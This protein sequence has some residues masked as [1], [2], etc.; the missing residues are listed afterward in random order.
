MKTALHWAQIEERSFVWGMRF[1]LRVYLI[2]GRSILQVF[3][4]PV[5]SY[6]WLLNRPARLASQAYLDR[7]A[8]FAPQ[9]KLH[10]SRYWSYCHFIS[11][12][13][14]IIDKL[15][16]WSG[17]LAPE[18]VIYRGRDL[19]L[20]EL[21]KGRGLLLLGA[22]LGNLEVCRAIAEFDKSIRINVLVHTKHAQKFN[23]LLNST[24][25]N[26]RLNL[27]QVTEITAA[28][29]QMLYDKIES[30]E[31]IIMAADRIPVN[32]WQ[33]TSKVNFLG[34]DAH[35]PQGPFILAGLLKC[36]VY[37]LICLKQGNKFVTY[38]EPFSAPI[39]FQKHR[40]DAD[41]R[42]LIQDYAARLESYCLQEPLQWFNFYDFWQGAHDGVE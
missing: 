26:S 30:G 32:N 42:Q 23:Q 33:R 3:L 37:T 13:N 17:A 5:V 2:F 1:L 21:E 39:H 34:S 24:N 14:S 38:F 6:Y 29:A 11:F 10:G 15:S 22:H 4:Y 7:L 12:A 31:L 19:L 25:A 27:L 18:D 40:R 9:L 41:I 35:F 28:T 16:A 8:V 20:K 36:P